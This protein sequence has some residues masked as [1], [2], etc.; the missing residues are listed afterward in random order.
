[1][2]IDGTY[3][4]TEQELELLQ[5]W[6]APDVAK[7]VDQQRTNAFGMSVAQLQKNKEK[8][9]VSQS[10]VAVEDV[11]H[12]P[13]PLSATQLHEITEQAQEQ[14]FEQGLAKGK[15]KG[16]AQGYEEGYSQGIEQGITTGTEQGL[17]QAQTL[18]DQKLALL[19]SLLSQ[20]SA[21]L[22]QQH[23]QIEL[24]LVNLS[25]TLAKKVI[26]TEISQNIEPLHHAIGQGINLLGKGSPINVALNPI[27]FEQISVM[28]D[29]Q[30]RDQHQLSFTPQP[31]I[32]QGDCLVESSASSVSF[33]LASRSAQV[34][35][36]LLGQE[37]PQTLRSSDDQLA[38]TAQP[39]ELDAN[40]A[41][42]PSDEEN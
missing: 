38:Q 4:P 30:A 25:L 35:D 23:E 37:R 22:A 32:N 3:K 17:A 12:S 34:F 6:Y 39:V 11:E 27:D 40:N 16:L 20:L 18:V 5:R 29:Q 2:A 14:G 41:P 8:R 9:I 19:E 28:W 10:E 33:D 36:D 21:P 15:E 1:M 26:H 13:A 31:S 24:A 42:N 7:K